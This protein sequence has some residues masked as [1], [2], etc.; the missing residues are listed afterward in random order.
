M[1]PSPV[2]SPAAAQDE[3][4]PPDELDAVLA[5][6]SIAAFLQQ[7]RREQMTGIMV[8]MIQLLLWPVVPAYFAER[9]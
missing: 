2:A 6:R 8:P 9:N 7:M 5:V 4:E 3:A 1:S